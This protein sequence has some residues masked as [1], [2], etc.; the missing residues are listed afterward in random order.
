MPHRIFRTNRCFSVI[1]VARS[2]W[3]RATLS[4]VVPLV[5]GS[6]V[7]AVVDPAS[8]TSYRLRIRSVARLRVHIS[9]VIILGSVVVGI[10]ISIIIARATVRSGLIIVARSWTIYRM[11]RSTILFMVTMITI[12]TTQRAKLD[13]L[14]KTECALRIYLGY[15]GYLSYELCLR[16]RFNLFP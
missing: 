15:S 9:I 7:I 16:I 13:Q 3:R 5:H 1:I 12:P 14:R 4:F 10:L 11:S 8:G 2:V 6:I